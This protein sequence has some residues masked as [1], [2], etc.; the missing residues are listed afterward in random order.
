VSA[1]SELTTLDAVA[2]AELVRTKQVTPRELVE[3]AV[4]RM[5]AVNPALNCVV[6]P[7]PDYALARGL[8][9]LHQTDRV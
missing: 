3:A 4:A 9:S 7:T 2:Q 1:V 8:A 6:I 5:E